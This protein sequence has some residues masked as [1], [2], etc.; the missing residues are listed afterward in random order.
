MRQHN[1]F[2][3]LLLFGLTLCLVS[4][5]VIASQAVNVG[6]AFFIEV[7]GSEKKLGLRVIDNDEELPLTDELIVDVSGKDSVSVKNEIQTQLDDTYNVK[8]IVFYNKNDLVRV[9]VLG[10]VSAPGNY[11]VPVNSSLGQLN[12]YA[13][14]YN[15]QQFDSSVTVVRRGKRHVVGSDELARMPVQTGDILLLSLNKKP[16]PVVIKK[17][18]TL[19]KPFHELQ[20][21]ATLATEHKTEVEKSTNDMPIEQKAESSAQKLLNTVN[22]YVLQPG[23]IL[24][25]SLPGEDGFN[26]DF[27][28]DRDGTIRLPEIGL[29]DIADKPMSVVDTVIYD[30]LS[31]AF[32]GLD[33]LSVHLKEKRL[34][35]TVLGFV[36]NPGEVELPDNANIQMAINA[37]GGLTDGAQLDKLQLKRQD[38]VQEFNFKRYLDTGDVDL[39]PELKTL[40]VI[41]VPSSPE[42]GNVHGESIDS[43]EGMDPTED[44][45][46]IKVFGE[47]ISP[48]SFPYKDGMN[49]VDA[50][51]R[52]GGVTR[53]SNVEQIRVID[54]GDPVLFNLKN[55]LD[56]GDESRLLQLSKGATIFVPKQVDAVQGGGRIVYVMGQVQKPGSF[57]TGD[58]VGFLDVLAN[59]GGPNRYADT[60]MVRILRSNGEVIPFNLQQYAEG[61]KVDMPKIMPGDAI[62]IPM[63]G[64]D[65]DKS[66]TKVKTKKSIKLMGAINKPGRY[67]WTEGITFL[68]LV[69]YAG[70][71]GKEADLAHIRILMPG[72]QGQVVTEE[73]NMQEF[74]EKGGNWSEVPDLIGGSTIIFPELPRSPTDNNAQ[75]VRLPKE[76]AIYMMGA[77]NGPGRFAFNDKLGLLDI[78]TAADGPSKDADLSRVRIVHRNEAAPRVSQVNL[79]EYFETGDE[80]LLPKVKPGD[81][82]FVPSIERSWVDKKKEDTVRVLGAVKTSGRYDFVNEM[83]ILDLLAEA[84]GPTNTAYVKKIII[85]NTS[86]CENQAYSFDL[87][88]FMKNPAASN[89]P[90]LRA[91][92]TIYIPDISKSYWGMFMAAVKDAV[93][94]LSLFAIINGL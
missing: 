77:V 7:D 25:V 50:L 70:G 18:P 52:A 27:I 14:L 88:G 10:D 46:A 20:D 73:F 49:L 58:N 82:I 45:T 87:E 15:Q 37:A 74:L 78:L 8:N 44:R 65:D 64:K 28:V 85:V 9:T 91:G 19:V 55:F 63:K 51:L 84:G 29:V 69:G 17:P 36:Q 57:E 33:K 76:Q 60:R 86:C 39:V 72:P 75:W 35:I 11:L 56:N 62:F 48:G 80:T 6:D 12:E 31:D 83:T 2:S 4:V 53:Y 22:E 47:V 23:D 81:S 71:P 54:Q 41:F 1:I 61:K 40:D 3:L 68:D 90:V 5:P 24:T 32:L 21:D 34:L 92:D 89:L 79:L 43:G 93:S 42:L 26:K 94:A 38:D 16:E 59:A 30:R 67:E 66:W 13:G